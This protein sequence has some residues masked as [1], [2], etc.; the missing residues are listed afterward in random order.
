MILACFFGE[1]KYKVY[2]IDRLNRFPIENREL[3]RFPK[4]GY[5]KKNTLSNNKIS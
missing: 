3:D 2:K 1:L 4:K 5:I